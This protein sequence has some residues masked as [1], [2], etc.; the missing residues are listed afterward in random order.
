MRF[1][2][3]LLLVLAIV[4]FHWKILL[5]HQFSILLGFE[6]ANLDYA[7]CHFAA[8]TIQ[9][10][11]LPLWDPYTHSGRNFLGELQTGFFYPLK[12]LLYLWPLNRFG[13]LSPQLF[14]DFFVLAHLLAA[15]F[16]F[17]LARELGLKCFPALVAALCFSLGGFVGKVGWP[18]MLDSAIWLPLIFLFLIRAL[19]SEW[20]GRG[21]LWAGLSGL[22]LGMAILAGRLEVPMMDVLGIV[23]AAAYFAFR[24]T[25]ESGCS[26]GLRSPWMWS[27]AVVAVT[28]VVTFAFAA[29]Q[30]LPSIEYSELAIRYLGAPGALPARQRIPYAD[31]SEALWPRSLLA[32][33]FGGASIGTG[34]FSPYFGVLP[35]LL[36]VMGVARNWERPWVKYLTALALVAFFNTLGSFSFLHGLLYALVPY[37]WM[38]REAGRFIYLTHFAMA[39]LA[40]FGAE[41]LFSEEKH[42]QEYFASLARVLKW[43]VGVVALAVGLP[44]VYGKPEVNEWIYFSFLLILGAYGL[45]LCVIRG[46]RTPAWRFLAVAV[47]LCDFQAFAWLPIQNKAETQKQGQDHLEVLLGC[48]NLANF[49]KSQPGLFR[50]Q[51]QVEWEPNIGD[52]YGIHTTGGFAATLLKDYERLLNGVPRANDLLNVRYFVRAKTEGNVKPVFN[53][54]KWVVYENPNY[55]PRAWVVHDLVIAPSR[56]Q[57]FHRISQPDFDPLRVAVVSKALEVALHPALAG[58]REEVR[59]ERYQADRVELRVRTQS[60][61][62]LVL[63]EVYYPGWRATVNGAPAQIHKVNGLLRGVVVPAGESQV[64]LSFAPR[65]VLLGAVLSGSTLLGTMVLAAVLWMKQRRFRIPSQAQPAS[66]SLAFCYAKTDVAPLKESRC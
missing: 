39:L 62:L 27:A 11:I 57:A 59:F 51:M 48:R 47:I 34:E 66:V 13:V 17:L 20:Q 1:R 52:L 60:R 43:I 23:S 5:T 61:G 25:R 64:T 21:I 58:P 41:T 38:A 35:L 4:L 10:G 63:S 55:C 6:G 42:H 46:H 56:D 36:V 8:A 26:S 30:L 18:H 49:F 7:R 19:R 14:Q 45:F 22:A 31:L 16:M 24:R 9:Q 15:G 53:D 2:W 28:G 33:P 12:L 65:S 40:G 54:G 44:A 37:L 32:I 3:F 29:I 50:V